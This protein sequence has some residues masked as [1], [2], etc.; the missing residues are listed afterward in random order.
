MALDNVGSVAYFIVAV[1]QIEP[2]SGII[3]RKNR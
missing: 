3:K 1:V 2:L